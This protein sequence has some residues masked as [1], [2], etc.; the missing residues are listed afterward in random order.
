MTTQTFKTRF[1]NFYTNSREGEKTLSNDMQWHLSFRLTVF[2][3]NLTL[4]R[5]SGKM[6]QTFFSKIL[7][8]NS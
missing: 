3:A 6:L 5:V 7:S 1:R 4:E 8:S 2:P